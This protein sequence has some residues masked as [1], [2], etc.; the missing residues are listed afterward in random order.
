MKQALKCKA[1]YTIVPIAQGT[2]RALKCP[3]NTTYF[4]LD[5]KVNLVQELFPFMKNIPP[6]D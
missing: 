3:V 6:Q 4:E 1:P 5:K 2:A